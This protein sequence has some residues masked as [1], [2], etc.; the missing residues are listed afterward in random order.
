[1]GLEPVLPPQTLRLKR[2]ALCDEG[3]TAQLSLGSAARSEMLR[4]MNLEKRSNFFGVFNALERLWIP[5]TGVH[6]I[7]L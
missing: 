6:T 7:D 4:N 3:I 1:M 5:L 2:T